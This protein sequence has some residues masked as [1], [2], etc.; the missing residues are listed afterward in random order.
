MLAT[1]H[2]HSYQIRKIEGCARAGNAGNVFPATDFKGNSSLAIPACK[3]VVRHARAVMHVG[4]ASQR[5]RGKCS[6]HS[7]RMRNPKFS[8]KRAMLCCVYCSLLHVDLNHVLES[9]WLFGKYAVIR[10][11]DARITNIEN[12][13][14]CIAWKN[15]WHY[16]TVLLDCINAFPPGQKTT[17]LQTTF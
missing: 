5:W 17:I 8:H 6:R 15:Y 1:K 10:L 9:H 7:R 4:I 13:G 3:L 11:S 16:H 12:V 2:C 14:K